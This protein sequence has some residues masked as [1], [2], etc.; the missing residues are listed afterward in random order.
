LKVFIR[1]A[2]VLYEYL[3]DQFQEIL[4]PNPTASQSSGNGNGQSQ[5]QSQQSGGGDGSNSNAGNLDERTGVVPTLHRLYIYLGDLHRYTCSYTSAEAAYLKAACLAPGKG[6]P[7][8]QLAVVAQ[9]KDS[10]GAHPLPAVAL[11][12]YCRSLLA[13]HDAF[14]TSRS[15]VE[16]LFMANRKW[17][18][19]KLDADSENEEVDM[20]TEG[21]SR[22]KGRAMR[23]AAS[24]KF[25]SLFCNFHGSLFSIWVRMVWVRTRSGKRCRRIWTT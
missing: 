23:S 8:N 12:W 7:Y 5:S 13:V 4:L 22:E 1:E 9:L 20:S 2:V 14:E 17:I 16:R 18:A 6:N 3:V 15:N 24:R 10:S 11:Y 25:L 19:Q 21:T